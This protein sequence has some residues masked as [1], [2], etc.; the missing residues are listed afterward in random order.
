MRY[1]DDEE[2]KRLGAEDWQLAAMGVNPYYVSWGPGE[3]Y[4][5]SPAEDGTGE[6]WDGSLLH[7]TWKDF[8]PWGLDDLNELVNFY[9]SVEKDSKECTCGGDGYH[10]EARD[11]VD[12]FYSKILG[13]SAWYNKITQD[14]VDALVA[15]GRLSRLTRDGHHPTAE[16]VNELN[17]GKKSIIDG[18]DAINRGILIRAR[19]GR[20]GKKVTCESCGGHG[21]I[22]T[23]DKARLVLILWFLHPRKGCSR[24]V[25]IDNIEQEELPS[26]YAYLREAAERNTARFGKIPA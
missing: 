7:K 14:E 11:I 10:K 20:L 22:F 15:A 1:P 4:M 8:G 2:A 26:V 13:Q 18:H 12:S 23:S 3:D 5:G 21:V 25:Q 19:C 6:G 16:E 17:S 9:F 24:G